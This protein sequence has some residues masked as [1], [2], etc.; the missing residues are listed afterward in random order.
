MPI[1]FTLKQGMVKSLNIKFKTYVFDTQLL[2]T[3]VPGKMAN[4]IEKLSIYAY[5]P[6]GNGTIVHYQ[7]YINPGCCIYEMIQKIKDRKQIGFI[8]N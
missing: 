6:I 8:A 4:S 7:M 5:G 1:S 2:T 3:C